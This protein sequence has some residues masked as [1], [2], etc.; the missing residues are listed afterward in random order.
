MFTMTVLTYSTPYSHPQYKDSEDFLHYQTFFSFFLLYTFFEPTTR[1]TFFL[2]TICAMCPFVIP[3]FQSLFS[4]SVCLLYK[5]TTY[6]HKY[7]TNYQIFSEFINPRT[8]Q[9]ASVWSK[10]SFL[11]VLFLV[12]CQVICGSRFATKSQIISLVYETPY[13]S[14]SSS[15]T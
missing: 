2:R 10:F 7:K 15:S 3:C 1:T 6:S 12:Y 4:M 14:T 13:S 9:Y 11:S 8:A 5:Y